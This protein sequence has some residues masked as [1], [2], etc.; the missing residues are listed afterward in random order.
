METVKILLR[1]YGEYVGVV[2]IFGGLLWAHPGL[3]I[4]AAGLWLADESG[5]L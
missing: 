5:N 3:A 1:Q 4:A 2:L